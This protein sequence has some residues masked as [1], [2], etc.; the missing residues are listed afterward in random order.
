MVLTYRA[1]VA[2]ADWSTQSIVPAAAPFRSGTFFLALAL[3]GFG[4]AQRYWRGVEQAPLFADYFARHEELTLIFVRAFG[5]L[6][7]DVEHDVL[8]DR[9][10]AAGAGI[11]GLGHLGDFVKCVG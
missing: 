4:A 7:H 6:E 5:E 11:L 10:E 2:V 8:D 1:S 9:A 3:G